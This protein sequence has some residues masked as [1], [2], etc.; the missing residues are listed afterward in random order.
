MLAVE[1][2]LHLLVVQL[3]D[4][5]IAEPVRKAEEDPL[6]LFASRR[7]MD[8]PEADQH[9]VHR[10]DRLKTVVDE[11]AVFGMGIDPHIDLPGG[12]LREDLAAVLHGE[13][14]AVTVRVLDLLQL[15]D[16]IEQTAFQL[17][18]ARRLD[19]HRRSGHVEAEDVSGE[20]EPV[21]RR[22]P[23]VVRLRLRLETRLAAEAAQ[24]AVRLQAQKIS[25]VLFLLGLKRPAGQADGAEREKRLARRDLRR[26]EERDPADSNHQHVLHCDISFWFE[27][28]R[29][30]R[31]WIR[32][33]CRTS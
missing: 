31:S 8:P 24:Q 17:L 26:G 32:R 11:R 2:L 21:L 9:L 6:R 12:D 33:V 14:I 19:G 30:I 5:G 10:V 23:S 22:F 25:S 20:V 4:D 28:K 16:N 27:I 13:R 15:I 18:V 29:I 7:D 3:L 1:H